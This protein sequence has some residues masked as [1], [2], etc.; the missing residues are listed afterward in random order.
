[1]GPAQ[2][3]RCSV[4]SEEQAR[5][6]IEA[7]A[8][9]V[10][11]LFA[12]QA[13]SA[14]FAQLVASHGA[15]VIPTLGVLYARCARRSGPD[16]V[17]D[18]LLRPYIRPSL[19]GSM[20]LTLPSRGGDKSC[21]GTTDAVRQLAERRVPILAGTDAPVPGQTYGASL[22]GELELLVS[23]GL[24]PLQ[25]LTAATS[26]PALAF[27]LTDRGRI[28]AGLRADLVLVEGD[29]SKDIP[30]TCRIVMVWKRGVPVSRTRYEE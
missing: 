23:A 4:L 8:D 13:V 29:P 18:S 11:H 24:T 7:K 25:A 27:G 6:A 5:T 30:A 19:R 1:M 16:I 21:Q 22:H 28:A 2:Q 20:S 26:A 14:G 15:F 10:A 3:D 17:T 9:G 12:A